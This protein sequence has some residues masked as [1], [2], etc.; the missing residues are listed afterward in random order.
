M[1]AEI[2][3]SDKQTQV[4]DEAFWKNHYE[5][6]KLSG[7]SRA[8]YCR[9]NQLNYDRFGYWLSK[10]SAKTTSFVSVKIKEQNKTETQSVLCTITLRAGSE[11]KIHDLSALSF[12]LE[13]MS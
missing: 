12:I 7:I 13:R 10:W 5:Q 4:E 2:I 11:I 3:S 1:N 8:Q 9:I 6:L